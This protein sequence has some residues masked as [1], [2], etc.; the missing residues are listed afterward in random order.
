MC[1]LTNEIVNALT[2]PN[3]A[4]IAEMGRDIAYLYSGGKA[5]QIEVKKG[6]RTESNVQAVQGLHAGDTLII[7][8]VM[9]LRD[10]LPVNID[11]II[12]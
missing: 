11:N 8:G 10:G 12:Q 4:I 3:E 5:K 6:L 7:T 1:S 2:I 9:Q